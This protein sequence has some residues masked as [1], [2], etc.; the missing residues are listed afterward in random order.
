MNKEIKKL[1]KKQFQ[2]IRE[3]LNKV[4]PLGVILDN[5]NLI[6]EYDLE[7]QKILVSLNKISNYIELAK[8]ITNIFKETVNEDYDEKLF[9]DCAK[10]IYNKLF[11]F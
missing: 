6:D 3:E 2:I 1:Y 4:D 7:T 11:L 8:I 5:P 9:Y 10:N